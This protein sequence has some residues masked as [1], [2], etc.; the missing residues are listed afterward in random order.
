MEKNKIQIS[1]EYDDNKN[2]VSVG[3]CVLVYEEEYE[4]LCE[5]VKRKKNAEK[6][7]ENEQDERIKKLEKAIKDLINE[8][9]YL[10]G[11]F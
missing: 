5:K 11:D 4:T 7:K 2:V 9:H 1:V 10:K 8:I 6:Q 3:K